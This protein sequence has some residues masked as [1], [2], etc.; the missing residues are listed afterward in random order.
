[1]KNYK[2]VLEEQEEGGFVAYVPTLP[3]C[4]TQGETRDE[5]M[6]NIKEAISVYVESLSDREL[7][8]P[9]VEELEVS[10]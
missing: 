10:V 6:N 9:Q 7:P 8:L 1:M 5:T 4:A 3:G 2:V